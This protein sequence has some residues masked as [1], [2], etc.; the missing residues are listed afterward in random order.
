MTGTS[1]LTSVEVDLLDR[2]DALWSRSKEIIQNGDFSPKSVEAVC[3]HTKGLVALVVQELPLNNSDQSHL[4][5]RSAQRPGP[6]L[7]AV[8]HH[9]VFDHLLIWSESRPFQNDEADDRTRDTQR[10]HLVTLFETLITQSRQPVLFQVDILRPLLQFLFKLSSQLRPAYNKVYGRTLYEVCVLVCRNSDCLDLCRKVSEDLFHQPHIIFSLLIPLIHRGDSVG[11]CIRDA[12]LLVLSLSKRDEELGNYLAYQSD[13]CPIL[14]TGL[15]GLYSSLPKKLIPRYNVHSSTCDSPGGPVSLTTS[16]LI[17]PNSSTPCIIELPIGGPSWHQ[18]TEDEWNQSA[19]LRRFL[20]T[21]DFCNLAI[22]ISHRNVQKQLLYYIGS[23]FLTPVLGS[24]LHQSALDEVVAATAYLELILRRLTESSLIKLLLKFIL[25]S[26]YDS[27]SV[28]NSLINRLNANAVL[29]MVTLSLF[30]TILSFHCEDVMYELIFRHLQPLYHLDSKV[31]ENSALSSGRKRRQSD[32]PRWVN[33]P[34][35][36]K[37]AQGA[38]PPLSDLALDLIKSGSRFLALATTSKLNPR[39]G[40]NRTAEYSSLLKVVDEQAVTD[41]PPTNYVSRTSLSDNRL[42]TNEGSG[43]CPGLATE[44]DDA[45]KRSHPLDSKATLSVQND[46]DPDWVF[47]KNMTSAFTP[48]E[49]PSLLPYIQCT[50]SRVERYRAACSVWSSNY[51]PS[52]F[53]SPTEDKSCPSD[54]EL[55]TRELQI[56]GDM[57]VSPVYL[58]QGEQQSVLSS[59]QYSKD[60]DYEPLLHALPAMSVARSSSLYQL[61]YLD[62]LFDDDASCVNPETVQEH[63]PQEFPIKDVE[64]HLPIHKSESLGELSQ[65]VHA[66]PTQTCTCFSSMPDI[67]MLLTHAE[68]QS[69]TGLPMDGEQLEQFL[70]ALDKVPSPWRCP[71]HFGFLPPVTSWPPV[72]DAYLLQL[73]DQFRHF[74]G[75]CNDILPS[76]LGRQP[77]IAVDLPPSPT[78]ISPSA[79]S[80]HSVTVNAGQANSND[81]SSQRSP[82]AGGIGPFLSILLNRLA[83]FHN[84]CF[85]T[86]LLLT[87]LL[88]SLAAY[89]CPLLYEFLLNS[90]GLTLKSNVNSVY[91]ALHWVRS[92]ILVNA[93]SIDN[94][95]QLLYRA[96]LYMNCGRPY[97]TDTLID[98]EFYSPCDVGRS[99]DRSKKSDHCKRPR[100]SSTSN[101]STPLRPQQ[102]T[103]TIWLSGNGDNACEESVSH[104]TPVTDSPLSYRFQRL[105]STVRPW[106]D[107]NSATPLLPVSCPPEQ[108]RSF[109]IAPN[110]ITSDSSCSSLP[111]KSGHFWTTTG[112]MGGTFRQIWPRSTHVALSPVMVRTRLRSYFQRLP[113]GVSPRATASDESCRFISSDSEDDELPNICQ[114]P[115]ISTRTRNLVFAAVIFDE[116]CHELAALCFVHSMDPEVFPIRTT[117]EP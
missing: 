102:E 53:M 31:S 47:V 34:R 117:I 43:T 100:S 116:F 62:D 14:A 17:N 79:L 50:K 83:N 42:S 16:A 6:L 21:L 104:S 41:N 58:R 78:V 40:G 74:T 8:V 5:S 71:V 82:I 92:Q 23:G 57:Q 63:S 89:P 24:A 33:S 65:V 2:L 11:D 81:A 30:R 91:K 10:K 3:S 22:K 55:E 112:K 37:T 76:D 45:G 4:T 70:R 107:S 28:L 87:D 12:L 103:R 72:D 77:E 59:A 35:S 94:W 64:T 75:P 90:A 93:K 84:N 36:A 98:P 60:D 113:G 105:S 38:H 80:L 15:S 110:R 101:Y 27:Y 96:R 39:T 61:N 52:S 7:E 95:D 108:M 85:F 69:L 73:D 32:I 46:S 109:M 1:S 86:N 9:R 48:T 44:T 99:S 97:A 67:A 115:S 25:T 13:F 54:R 49:R 19:D 29:G 106:S 56:Q 111:F 88:T 51:S 114:Q 18:L 66:A 68:C 20:H 26:T